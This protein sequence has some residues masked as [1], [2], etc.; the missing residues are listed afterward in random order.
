[1]EAS[2]TK[3]Y[4]VNS[5][6][7]LLIIA[8]LFLTNQNCYSQLNVSEDCPTA[9]RICDVTQSYYFES[10]GP[11]LIDD[12]YGATNVYCINQAGFTL[13]ENLAAWFIFTPQYS[14]EFGFLICPEVQT[15]DW[16]FALFSNPSCADL[17]NTAYWL[18]C[19]VFPPEP[20]VDGCTG[21]GFKNGFFW[22]GEWFN[23]LF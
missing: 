1:M 14:G 17:N 23:P 2:L 22:G 8:M 21:I 15:D 13:W 20:E 4:Y 19:S 12:A 6:R 11:G 3:K 16:S 10:E 5:K 7:A 9:T 18:R